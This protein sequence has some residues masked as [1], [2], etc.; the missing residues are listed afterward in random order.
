MNILKNK[1][2]RRSFLR[3][4]TKAGL[5][6]PFASQFGLMSRAFAVPNALYNFSIRTDV[7][8]RDGISTQ[9]VPSGRTV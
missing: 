2:Q 4:L 1:M 5:V 7:I 6:L 3:T 9:R 8:S